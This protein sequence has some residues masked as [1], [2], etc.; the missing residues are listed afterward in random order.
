MSFRKLALP[1]AGDV[2]YI[3]EKG[4]PNFR[5]WKEMVVTGV[6]R[7]TFLAVAVKT[8]VLELNIKPSTHEWVSEKPEDK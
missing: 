4:F 8:S 3:R 2:L 1:K 6:G 7:D 5:P